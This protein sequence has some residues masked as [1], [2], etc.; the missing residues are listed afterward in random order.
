MKL[1]KTANNDI[2]LE[3]NL[4]SWVVHKIQQRLVKIVSMEGY[5]M[6]SFKWENFVFFYKVDNFI[7]LD[8]VFDSENQQRMMNLT[9]T[10]L[11][12]HSLKS[13]KCLKSN[14]KK[15]IISLKTKL[16]LLIIN[17]LVFSCKI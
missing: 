9:Q 14:F 10:R 1:S 15:K 2:R 6:K 4:N 5:I 7:E 17:F 13:G 8:H 3:K 12:R 11:V 16:K